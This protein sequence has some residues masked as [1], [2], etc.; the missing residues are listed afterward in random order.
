MAHFPG[1][2][3]VL[4]VLCGAAA[5]LGEVAAALGQEGGLFEAE[6]RELAL[7]RF[8]LPQWYHSSTI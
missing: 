3:C 1:V 7:N 8:L 4:L 5:G 2:L 6:V